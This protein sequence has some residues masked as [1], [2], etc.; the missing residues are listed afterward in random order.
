MHGITP[1]MILGAIITCHHQK[2]R[3]I[4]FAYGDNDLYKLSCVHACWFG[5]YILRP[6]HGLTY[7]LPCT[8]SV[9]NGFHYKGK[10]VCFENLPQSKERSRLV[11]FI[12]WQSF[13]CSFCCQPCFWHICLVSLLTSRWEDV[14]TLLQYQ[15]HLHWAHVRSE[16]PSVSHA[17]HRLEAVFPQLCSCIFSPRERRASNGMSNTYK[18]RTALQSGRFDAP[19]SCSYFLAGFQLSYQENHVVRHIVSRLSCPFEIGWGPTNARLPQCRRIWKILFPIC[20]LPTVAIEKN[21]RLQWFRRGDTNAALE[22]EG[23]QTAGCRT[24][25]QGSSR[26][27]IHQKSESSVH[28]WRREGSR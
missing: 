19:L 21:I 20:P 6:W 9:V 22:R 25:Y 18:I 15:R 10:D 4:I 13:R 11:F 5:A 12:C 28:P 26:W 16:L 3:R 2:R 8:N 17:S 7:K 24:A 27:D 14:L 1:E 23:I